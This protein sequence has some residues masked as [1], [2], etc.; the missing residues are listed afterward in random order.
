MGLQSLS[1]QITAT[2]SEALLSSQWLSIR[3]LIGSSEQMPYFPL[4]AY[5]ALQLYLDSQVFPPFTILILSPIPIQFEQ[6]STWG[7]A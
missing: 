5:V 2:Q 6:G 3:L 7:L 1:S 4:L